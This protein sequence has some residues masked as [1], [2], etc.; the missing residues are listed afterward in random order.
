MENDDGLAVMA[1]HR[2]GW[3]VFCW[4]MDYDVMS[5]ISQSNIPRSSCLIAVL[6][7]CIF[8]HVMWEIDVV[9]THR[10]ASMSKIQRSILETC[11]TH[12]H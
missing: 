12:S 10:I 6:S 4:V 1:K 5:L 7:M 8:W 9:V 2:I 11:H 3:D